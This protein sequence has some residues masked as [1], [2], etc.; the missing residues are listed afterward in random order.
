MQRDLHEEVTNKIISKLEAG[1]LPWMKSWD[2][3]ANL[4]LPT[5]GTTHKRYNGVNICLLWIAAEDNGFSTSEW[6][7]FN[8]WRDKKEMVAKGSKGTQ[9]IYYDTIEKVVEGEKEIIPFVKASY[10]FNKCQLQGYKMEEKEPR[11]L[12]DRLEH[13][14]NY[15][16]NTGAKIYHDGGNRAFYSPVTDE[17]HLPPREA[18]TDTESMYSVTLH[19][20]T[21]FTAK[22]GRCDREFGKRFGDEAYAFEELVAELGSA[23]NCAGLEICNEPRDDTAAYLQH[24]LTILKSDKKAIFTASKEA[25]KAVEYLNSL[26]PKEQEVWTAPEFH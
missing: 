19:E 13:V 12:I 2:T 4:E 15:I 8:Q 20:L 26:Q 10:V 16:Q 24:W 9:I 18:F 22:K 21:H 7:S 25:S 3:Q 17:I 23:F 5:N 11:P 1:S 6:G 14:D